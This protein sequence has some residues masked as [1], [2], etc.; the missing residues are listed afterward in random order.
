MSDRSSMGRPSAMNAS[1]SAAGPRT[2]N[3]VTYEVIIGCEVHVQLLTKSKA[4]CAC[5]NR[6]GGIPNTRVCPVCLGLPGALPVVN[7]ALVEGAIL[8]GL[9]LGSRIAEVTKFDRKNYVY[10]DL[11]KGY[12]ISQ[13]DMPVCAGGHLDVASEGEVRRVGIT[14]V[15]MEED[16]GKNLHLADGSNMSYVDFNRCGTPLLEIVSEPDMRS[17][18]EA[19]A[20]VE[21]IREIMRYLEISDCNMEEGSL[22]CDANINLWIHEGA[23]KYA[24][25]IVEI[26]NMNSFR[27]IRSALSFEVGRQ[28]EEW[29]DRRLTLEAVGKSTRG[30]NDETGETVPQRTKEAASDYRYFPEPDLKPISISP[31]FVDAL[32]ARVGELPEA[33]RER[34]KSQYG[35]SDFDAE[36]LVASK[37]L[38]AFFEEASAGYREPKRIANW[39]LTEVRSVLNERNVEIGQLPSKPAHIRELLESVDDGTISGK[40]AKEVFAE[41][42][43]GGRAPRE[44]ITERGLSQI[45][46]EGDLSEIVDRVIAANEKSVADYGAGKDHALKYLMGQVMKESKGKANPVVATRLLKGRLSR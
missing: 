1:Q 41:M 19:V 42:V 38:S 28:I 6:F 23:A 45:A 39:I 21:S 29:K 14:R 27:A 22:R 15:H 11:P 33:K 10:P 34:L 2:E 43:E 31:S 7:L 35:L 37:P 17:P 3:G 16:A 18:E 30:Y 13:F 5:E 40:I 36:T 32:R 26:K 8:A 46:D 20:F 9:A 25:P 24:T 44:I 4:F 12:Q